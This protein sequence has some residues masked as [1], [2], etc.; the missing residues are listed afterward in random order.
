M[1]KCALITGVLGQDGSYLA[2]FLL[3]K[4]YEV[5]GGHRQSSSMNTWR[6]DE[7][8]VVDDVRFVPVDLLDFTNIL[9]IIQQ[10]KPNEVYNLAA[11][12]SVSISFK[13]PILTSEVD[14]LGPAR[15]LEVLRSVCPEC[16]FYQASSS[17][18]FGKAAETPQG[19]R[20]SFYPRSPYAISKLYAHW[21]TV[22]YREAYGMHTAS[23]ILFN[24]ESP[25]RGIEFV[26]RKITHGLAKIRHG[27]REVLELGNLESRRDWGFAG[28]YVKGMWMM[29][30]QAE[31]D[32]YVL[33][34]GENHSV[35][36][37]IDRAAEAIGFKL[38]WQGEGDQTKAIDRESGRLIIRVNPEFY[39]PTEV[40][41]LVG[42]SS[43]ARKKLGWKTE[44]SF[45]QL[46]EMMV[47]ADM[48]RV[49]KM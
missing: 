23:G 33:A 22:N 27:N 5:Y 11:Q 8:G 32:D 1:K 41:T 48:D 10:I 16:C 12:S 7:L 45:N 4:G 44:V 6:L 26:T 20:T 38:V 37:F 14:A 47:M 24:H 40:D 18:M 42:D 19:E 9:R 25:L 29:L 28:D 36:E 46:V 13:Q 43:K 49:A 3:E 15:I 34:T 17:E 35:R 39:R 21:I 2:R 31:R 30:Q